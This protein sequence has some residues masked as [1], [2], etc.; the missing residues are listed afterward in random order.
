MF[1]NLDTKF[2]RKQFYFFL[3]FNFKF[4]PK[5]EFCLLQTNVPQLIKK[6]F[7]IKAQLWLNLDSMQIFFVLYQ[8][9]IFANNCE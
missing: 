6:F 7:Y 3:F 9:I 4:P 2:R 5:S 8:T 1:R